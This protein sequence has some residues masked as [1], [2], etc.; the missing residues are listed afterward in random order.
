[1]RVRRI[2]ISSHPEIANQAPGNG[3]MESMTYRRWR[4]NRLGTLGMCRGRAEATRFCDTCQQ[5]ALRGQV[6]RAKLNAGRL[7]MGDFYERRILG[8]FMSD[9]QVPCGVE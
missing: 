7:P 5:R 9:S 3:Q 2:R 6:V 1:M 4:R 8:T